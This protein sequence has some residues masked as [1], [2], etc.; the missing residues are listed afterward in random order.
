[1][2]TAA[3]GVSRLSPSRMTEAWLRRHTRAS[4]TCVRTRSNAWGL[5]DATVT[6]TMRGTIRRTLGRGAGHGGD[7]NSTMASDP[8]GGAYVNAGTT[9]LHQPTSVSIK[10]LARASLTVSDFE[11][12]E[13]R[14]AW[15]VAPA[16]PAGHGHPVAIGGVE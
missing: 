12:N 15:P 4:C 10:T 6:A 3:S 5:G 13:G 9:H 14:R 11:A 16:T 1:M 2:H 8:S 7:D